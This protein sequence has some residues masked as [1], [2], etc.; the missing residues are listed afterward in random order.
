MP[1]LVISSE[2]DLYAALDRLVAEQAEGKDLH[3]WDVRFEGWPRYEITIR[4]EDFD[5]GIPTRIMPA[6][7]DL[8]R[9]VDEAHARLVYGDVRRLSKDERRETEL[10]VRVRPGS[11]IFS[12][13]LSQVLTNI[14]QQ[15]IGKMTGTQIVVSILSVAAITGG[16]LAFKFY[17]ARRQAEKDMDIKL[18]LS[19]EE[20][21][22]LEVL[23]RAIEHSNEV[24]REQS[25]AQAKAYDN[26]LN[27]L[28]PTDR[29]VDGGQT[30]IDGET[31]RKLA[32]AS[33][34]VSVDSRLDGEF[35][36]LSVDSGGVRGG[37][38]LHV[39]RKDDEMD[40]VVSV[41]EGTLVEQQ[42]RTLQEGEWR[43][44]SLVMQLNTKV[45]GEKIVEA[46]LVQAGLAEP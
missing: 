41:P 25:E 20:T 32:R 38:K 27:R 9:K 36:I 39:R 42:I 7:L 43:K 2:Q 10:I 29:I 40:L 35:I 26:L 28:H 37:Y 46:T 33:R 45:R 30:L 21:R 1:Q 19:A 16:V 6:L 15:A 22:R 23:G 4:G 14:A 12:T 31:G 24:V 17:L 34:Q 5:G 13:D 11:S 18:A 8:Q 3:D 44:R